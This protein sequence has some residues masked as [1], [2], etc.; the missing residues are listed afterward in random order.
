MK[1]APEAH[2]IQRVE[3]AHA[4]HAPGLIL[5]TVSHHSLRAAVDPGKSVARSGQRQYFNMRK[6]RSARLP[7]ISEE[8]G[9]PAARK[10]RQHGPRASC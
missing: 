6:G 4:D 3:M 10:V 5:Q 8:Y 1:T 7:E 9:A 2:S